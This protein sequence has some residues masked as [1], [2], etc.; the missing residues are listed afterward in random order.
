M[1]DLKELRTQKGI[2]QKE[3]ADKCDVVRQTISNIECGMTK[4]SVELAK[5]MA[6]V[7]DVEWTIFFDD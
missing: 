2:S 4:P 7:L 5:K 6:V 1:I 3:L